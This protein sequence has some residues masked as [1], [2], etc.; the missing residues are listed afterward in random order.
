MSKSI[1]IR[2][3]YQRRILNW[4]LDHSGSVSKISMALNIRTPHASFALSEL[5]K[6]NLVHRDDLHGIRGAIHNITEFGRKV[7]EEDRL[8]LYKRYVAKIEQEYD[9]I[10]L[11]S[12]DH[13]L[14]LCYHKNPPNSLFPLPIDPF[15]DNIDPINNSSGTDGGVIWA[16]VVPESIKWYS[17]ESLEQITPP[18]ELGMGTLDAWLQTTDSFAL[19]RAVLFKPTNQWNVPP[20]TI[21]NTPTY[22]QSEV[23]DILSS[24][25]HNIGKILG[26]GL[27]VSWNTR[28]HAHLTSEIDIN[29]L[30]NSFSNNAYVLRKNPI[31]PDVT[32]LPIDSLYEWLKLRHKR[33]SEEKLMAKFEQIKSVIDNESINSLSVPL[34]K[35][36]SRDFGYCEWINETPENID[37]SNLSI[38][39]VKSIIMYLRMTYSTEYVV[40]WDWDIGSNSEFLNNIIRDSNC[41]L[42]VTKLGLPSEI[43]SSFA[44]LNSLPDLAIARLNLSNQHSLDLELTSDYDKQAN[45]AHSLIPRD[46]VE[47]LNAYD[48]G[49]WDLT[50]MTSSSNDFEFRTQ[51]WQ[52]LNKY[53]LGDETWSNDI[54]TSNPL[55]AWI[56]TPNLH[57][58]SRWIRIAN[59]LQDSWADLMQCENT[60]PKLLASSIN[61]ASEQWKLN[62]IKQISQ[63]FLTDNQLLI[64]M[65][66]GT[67]NSSQS[68]AISTAILLICDKLP[69]EFSSYVRNAVDEWLDSPLFANEILES[70]FREN[71][72]GDFDRFIVYDKVTLASKIH[73]KNSILYNWGRYVMCLKNSDLISNELMRNFISLLPFHWWYGN[74][75]D[76]LVSQLSSSAGRRWLAEQRI[77]WPGL[78]FRLDGEIWGPPGFR[79]KFVRRIPASNDL[80]FIP[81]MQDCVAKDY[82]MD[83]YDLASKVEDSNFR[84]TARTHPKLGFLLRELNEWPN[85]SVKIIDEGDATIGALIFGI[86]YHKNLN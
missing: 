51:I 27:V 48:N 80:L 25:D 81:I 46:A 76:W 9:G 71:S 3:R 5:R 28:L 2:S 20:G 21:F 19:V 8:R 55:A 43:T 69:N 63:H 14:L 64:E 83:V 35:E 40:E 79:K 66:K 29:L 78:I 60:S 10:V 86:S 15:V 68:S 84:I 1:R 13:E 23:P 24:G 56:A 34:Q 57:R 61:M 73:P 65:R 52:A 7:L 47:L 26:T 6:K 44:T 50:K 32:T 53:P 45:I 31:K 74:S 54:E 75:S 17:A 30:I 77:P 42:L 62:A 70:L 59:K 36:I 16:S 85:F 22:T 67:L 37:I 18:N 72:E 41:R 12:K 11:Q 4:L 39:G 82:L 58:E 33:L 49:S 38:D